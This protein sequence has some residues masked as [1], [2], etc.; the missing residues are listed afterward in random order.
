MSFVVETGAGLTNANSYISV[1]DADTYVADHGNEAVWT[2]ATNAQKEAALRN[3][4]QYIDLKYGD[5]FKSCKTNIN[6]GSRQALQFPRISVID[7]DGYLYDDDEIP[8]CL[9]NAVVEAALRI[10]AGDDLLGVLESATIQSE[11]STVGP[12]S[13]S[14]TYVGGKSPVK[15]YPKIYSLLKPITND[16]GNKMLRG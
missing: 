2:S 10:L 9:K 7:E 15:R 13:E 4:T 6:S 11:S 14:I 1:A 16:T 8:E 12:L 5:K 3:A